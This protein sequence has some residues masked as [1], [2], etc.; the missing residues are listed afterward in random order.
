MDLFKEKLAVFAFSV[1][2]VPL[3]GFV[4]PKLV[5]FTDEKTVLKVKLNYITKNHLGSMYF[6]AIAM[7]AEAAVAI[8]AFN[9][10]R[11][12]GQKVDLIFKDFQI[13]FL[14]RVETDAHFI[15]DQTSKVRELV[16]QTIQTGERV[17]GT[18]EGQVVAKVNGVDEVVSKY[19]ITLSLKC[20]SKKAAT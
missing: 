1:F 7:A 19:Q 6:G 13:D 14:K 16:L 10:I 4:S 18:C 2:K 15:C 11:K 17:S 20:R 3:L 8:S 5:E 12:S 9:E